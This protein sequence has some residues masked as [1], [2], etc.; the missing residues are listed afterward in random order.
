M[1]MAYA[2]RPK[3]GPTIA[4]GPIRLP[5]GSN[6]L[7]I[8]KQ[9]R[10]EAHRFALTYHRR[11]RLKRLRESLLDEVPGIGEKRKQQV[12]GHFGSVARL[13]RASLEDLQAVPGVGP[14]M[15]GLIKETIGT[16][17][18][19]TRPAPRPSESNERC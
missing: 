8:C 19:S 18:T 16:Y 3:G 7:N 12:L 5:E 13:R 17:R 11:L 14:A 6:A 10:D 9:I 2:R 4:Q 15:A 1:D